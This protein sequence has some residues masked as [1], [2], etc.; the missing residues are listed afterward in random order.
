[1]IVEIDGDTITS[2]EQ[3]SSKVHRKDPGEKMKLR[4]DRNGE[5]FEVEV[6]LAGLRQESPQEQRDS[7]E[8]KEP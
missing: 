7:S 6:T 5:T 1:M 3:V 8:R 2:F 4:V